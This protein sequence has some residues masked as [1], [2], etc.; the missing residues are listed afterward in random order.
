MEAITLF[1]SNTAIK[2]WIVILLSENGSYH[3][4]LALA[5]FLS[6]IRNECDVPIYFFLLK[7]ILF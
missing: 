5:E 6:N 7:T 3:I 2:L 4:N 1:I